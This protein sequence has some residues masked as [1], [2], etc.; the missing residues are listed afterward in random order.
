M[1]HAVC[2]TP[3]LVILVSLFVVFHFPGVTFRCLINFVYLCIFV[4]VFFLLCTQ[5]SNSENMHRANYSGSNS[6]LKGCELGE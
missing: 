4:C 6:C 2:E 5:N 3:I 1:P